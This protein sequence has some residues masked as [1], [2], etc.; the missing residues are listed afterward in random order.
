MLSAVLEVLRHARKASIVLALLTS[1]SCTE[2]REPGSAS[3]PSL[4]H[5]M[6]A[7]G[8]PKALVEFAGG[9]PASVPLEAVAS[10][11]GAAMP[12]DANL[13]LSGPPEVSG[14]DQ[15]RTEVTRYELRG[16]GVETKQIVL[17]E[18]LVRDGAQWVPLARFVE[19]QP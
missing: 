3:T 18:L 6:I 9:D 7:V 12:A 11:I 13:L 4:T 2:P 19:V 15:V 5:D 17:R 1:V 8:D 10:S 14:G 16:S